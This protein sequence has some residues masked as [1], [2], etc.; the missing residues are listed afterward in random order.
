MLL[1]IQNIYFLVNV[2]ERIIWL[3]LEYYKISCYMEVHVC[4][5]VIS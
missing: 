1:D 4:T 5:I 2:T 3:P